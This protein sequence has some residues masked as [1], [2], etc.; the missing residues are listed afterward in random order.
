VA[1]KQVLGY[2]CLNRVDNYSVS[3]QFMKEGG[4]AWWLTC[5]YGPQGE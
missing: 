3:V 1:W 2:T 4:S 5:V